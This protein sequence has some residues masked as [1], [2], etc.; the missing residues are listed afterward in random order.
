MPPHKYEK[1]KNNYPYYKTLIIEKKQI[2]NSVI[3]VGEPGNNKKTYEAICNLNHTSIKDN[4]EL[5]VNIRINNHNYHQFKLKYKDYIPSPFFR[6][7]SDGGTHRNK[8]PGTPIEEQVVL[9]PHFHKYNEDGIEIAYQT[10]QLKDPVQ[11]EALKD[12]NLS[13]AHFFHESNTRLNEDDFP[14][15]KIAS[16]TFGFKLEKDDP[17]SNVGFI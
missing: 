16:N 10:E 4:M 17:N 3:E 9:T 15:I 2:E 1:I 12:I 13:V 11:V 6:F 7:D 5:I 14:E 8:I